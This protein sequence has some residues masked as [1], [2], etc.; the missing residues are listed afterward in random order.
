MADHPIDELALTAL[1]YAAGDL[2]PPQAAA[3]EGRMAADQ[4]AREA[5]GEAIRLSA[6]AL[7]QP[8]PAP[9]PL[10]RVA[11]REALRPTV[12]SR[13]FPRRPY[14][15]H[16]LAWAGLGAAAAVGLFFVGVEL[17]GPVSEPT[18]VQ[19]PPTVAPVIPPTSPEILATLPRSATVETGRPAPGPLAT[20]HP[21]AH[22][23]TTPGHVPGPA[24]EPTDMSQH[25]PTGPAIAAD[26]ETPGTGMTQPRS[27][28]KPG[29][30]SP[31]PSPSLLVPGGDWD[32]G[33]EP[34]L[35]G[36]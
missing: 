17:A 11:V 29:L 9:D 6:A 35:T 27:D 21:A 15:G 22:T 3:F 30:P 31:A 34:Q 13:I 4:D 23:G 7:H 25:L 26:P 10:I 33:P 19:A 28:P 1:R 36:W 16:P 32:D 2:P 24:G 18:A 8:V 14:R 20:N 12:I 5:L